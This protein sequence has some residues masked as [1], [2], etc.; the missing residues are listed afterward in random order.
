MTFDDGIMRKSLLAA[1]ATV[2][3]AF[4]FATEAALAVRDHAAEHCGIDNL[5]SI[6]LPE[7][8]RSQRVAGKLGMS[9]S[10]HVHNDALGIAVEIW[11]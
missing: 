2:T 6:I 3:L 11:S 4:G 8:A 1:C 7:N 9:L 10:H 5:I